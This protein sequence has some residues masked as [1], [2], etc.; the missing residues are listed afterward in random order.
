MYLLVN[1]ILIFVWA[2]L[3]EGPLWPIAP[4]AAWGVL[5]LINVYFA[6]RGQARSR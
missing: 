3:G 6:F 1:S 2:I 5:V 4:I